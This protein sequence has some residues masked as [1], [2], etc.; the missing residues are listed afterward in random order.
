[1]KKINSVTTCTSWKLDNTAP[2]AIERT[3]NFEKSLKKL[4][5][6]IIKRVENAISKI[7]KH[8]WNATW[9]RPHQLKSKPWYGW[10]Q[11]SN[12]HR[13]IYKIQDWIMTLLD[14]WPHEKMET[15]LVYIK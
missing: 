8:W 1:M 4:S 10:F 7:S 12:T 11:S 5:G 2:K 9:A 13:I 3:K 14:F 6:D 15:A